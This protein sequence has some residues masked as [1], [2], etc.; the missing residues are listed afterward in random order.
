MDPL[1]DSAPFGFLVARDDGYVEQANRTLADM[2]DTMV[3]GLVG[4]HVDT[5]LTTP[6]R[7]FYQSHFF[8]VLKLQGQVHE[9]YVNLNSAS[10]SEVPVLLNARRRD[11]EHGPRYDWALIPM[12]TR[13]EYENEIL[14]AR[15]V[16]EEAS[17]AKDTFLSFVSHELRSPLAAV[18]G[19]TALLSRGDVEPDKARRGLEAIDR[20]AKLQL[21]LV[22]DMLDHARLASGKVRVELTHLDARQVLEAV[23]DSL[24]ATAAAKKIVLKREIGAGN[25]GIAADPDRLQQVFWN[26][27]NNAVKFTPEG[28][29]VTAAIRRSDGWIEVTVTD[30][31]KG[32]TAAFLPYVFESFR[33]EEGRVVRAE[34]GLGLGMSITRQLIELHGGSIS[35]ASEGPG[36][37]S[38]FTLRL[39]AAPCAN[40]TSAKTP[41][42]HGGES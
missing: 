23:L 2:L 5:L 20:N 30:T 17:S 27:L 41:V 33:Q 10:G 3:E 14:K 15:R 31:G 36:K 21:K 40:G 12:R 34:G 38:T 42:H 19:W 28:G 9:V 16:A 7:I 22:D 24:E 39:P 18:I 8:P 29:R 35:A 6:S 1:L 4:H 26:V 11:T 37:G 32:I 25:M 13:N